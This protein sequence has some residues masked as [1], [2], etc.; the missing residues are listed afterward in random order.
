MGQAEDTHSMTH[1]VKETCAEA[2]V[3]AVKFTLQTHNRGIYAASGFH[4]FKVRLLNSSVL[5][6]VW[7]HWLSC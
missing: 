1:G 5:S 2:R 3:S 7:S 4:S 6:T